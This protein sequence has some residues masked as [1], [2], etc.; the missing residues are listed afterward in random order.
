LTI[1]QV[2]YAAFDVVAP[3][4]AYPNF[5][6]PRDLRQR[7]KA[8]KDAAESARRSCERVVY[9]PIPVCRTFSYI[10][11][12]YRGSRSFSH[13]RSLF[14]SDELDFIS[15]FRNFVFISLYHEMDRALDCEV[16]DVT[17]S[18]LDS[19]PNLPMSAA[20]DVLY[21]TNIPSSLSNRRQF[22]RFISS[23][24]HGIEVSIHRRYIIVQ[25]NTAVNSHR[26][27][28]FVPNL[29]F[30]G[31]TMEIHEFPFFLSQI[32]I[33]HWPRSRDISHLRELF[34]ECGSLE[35]AS[36]SKGRMIAKINFE[37]IEA[38]QCAI[39]RFDRHQID[40]QIISVRRGCPL[41]HYLMMK[42]YEVYVKGSHTIEELRAQFDQYG[43]IYLISCNE[44]LKVARVQFAIRRD[45]I[46]AVNATENAVFKRPLSTVLVRN[47][48]RG[49][50]EQ[51]IFQ[52]ARQFGPILGL[53]TYPEP[54][55]KSF[56]EIV[57][58][59]P[60]SAISL[61]TAFDKVVV[62]RGRWSVSIT[63]FGELIP[64]WRQQLRNQW[65]A[66]SRQGK[67][68]PEIVENLS[69][70][71]DIEDFAMNEAN[72]FVMFDTH[73]KATTAI[74]AIRHSNPGA[75]ARPLTQ[76]EFANWTN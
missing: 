30:D 13:L 60:S 5:P 41:D 19:D 46:R 68:E 33:E 21:F 4:V 52:V 76:L 27:R 36:I 35:H 23:F 63:G 1:R 58:E 59:D 43:P 53:K 15:E 39:A 26:I 69:Q 20:T 65:M 9:K 34:S 62:N 67:S 25:P 44:F 48:S 3:F 10:L 29:Q 11:V 18:E 64:Q 16:R 57:Y 6:E 54:N 72:A 55:S 42:E 74:E 24:G 61:R 14:Q 2:L 37:N 22:M 31:V 51:R 40:D 66:M 8:Q 45:A 12:D 32:L 38:V 73:E 70:Y 75:G 7:Q 17:N 49:T 71:G 50:S 28:A 56:V 47:V